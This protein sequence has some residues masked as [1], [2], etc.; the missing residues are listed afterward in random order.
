M[1]RRSEDS[2]ALHRR[3]EARWHE[4]QGERVAARPASEALR[5]V[6]E[7]EVHQIELEMQNTELEAA[8]SL[9]EQALARATDLFDFAPLG[10]VTLDLNG[11][12]RE[13]NLAASHLLGV[14]RSA[15]VGRPLAGFIA[16][17]A[18]PAFG[19]FLRLVFEGKSR[20]RCEL[21]MTPEAR[22]GLEVELEAA[23]TIDGEACRVALIDR[24][25]RNHAA[26]DR[27]VLDKLESTGILAGGIAHDF[28]NLLVAIILNLDMAL[29]GESASPDSIR[30]IEQ[31]KTTAFMARGLTQQLLTFS[32]GGAPVR[33][34]IGVPDLVREAIRPALGGSN[35]QCAVSMAS[36]LWPVVADA[37]QIGQVVRN[38]VLNARE[39]MPSG[40]IVSLRAENV[41]HRRASMPALPPGGF[42]R[43]S[44][45]DHGTGIAAEDLPK[46][47][48]PYFSTKQRGAKKGM[49]LGLTICHSIIQKHG[50]AITVSSVPDKGTTFEFYLPAAPGP[51]PPATAAPPHSAPRPCRVLVMDDEHVVREMCGLIL[52]SLG[53]A[54]EAVENGEHAIA[55]HARALL[56]G[57]P[58]GAVL[59]DLTIRNGIG[60]LDAFRTMQQ[61]E[62]SLTAIIMSG[63]ADDP[64]VND[65]KRHG[66]AAAL[67]KPFDSVQLQEALARVL[68]PGR[69]P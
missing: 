41:L 26:A 12:I 63:F 48:D 15:L 13:A 7:L 46:I 33:K 30:H 64:V 65:F 20:E 16:A 69:T 36:D 43:I 18:R 11:A 49:G 10:Y 29:A 58:F 4:R 38:L 8:R 47:F 34:T 23:A 35:V 51:P 54:V 42:V 62:P 57:E 17:A 27:L 14:D 66:F 52:C 24:T 39:A 45:T 3:A 60:G 9:A 21:P 2:A 32:R 68:E 53:H 61:A 40:G 50:G 5:L 25:E 55:A 37:D 28:N 59:L 56:R 1:E 19:R 22:P 67:V 31:A 6:H 44:V